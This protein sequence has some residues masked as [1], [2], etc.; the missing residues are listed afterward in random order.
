MRQHYRGVA[1]DRAVESMA[2]AYHI[3]D[4]PPIVTHQLSG[5]AI[6]ILDNLTTVTEEE[7]SALRAK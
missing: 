1:A 2:R 3:G 7:Q 5:H 6:D 4:S